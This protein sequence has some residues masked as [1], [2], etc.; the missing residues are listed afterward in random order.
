MKDF[1]QIQEHLRNLPKYS[2]KNEQKQ[3]ILVKL[4]QKQRTPSFRPIL[5]I[6][7]V[8]MILIVFLLTEYTVREDLF[9]PKQSQLPKIELNPQ[10]GKIFVLPD[11]KQ[12]VI[13]VEGKV[14]ILKVFNHIVA[15]DPRRISKLMI[16]YWGNSEKIA[17]NNYRIEAMNKNAEKITLAEGKLNSS[18]YSK[19][20]HTL[21]SFTPFPKEGEWQL[22]FYVDDSLFGEFTL[23]V[24]PPFPKTKH[25]ILSDSP[26]EIK[27]GVETEISIE[28]TWEDKKDIEVQLINNKGKIVEQKTFSQVG[29]YIDSATLKPLYAFQGKLM[30]PKKGIW[31]LV[32]DG[33]KTETFS[34]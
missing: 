18:L 28:S 14:A 7:A 11:T 20:A 31:T 8:F 24:L 32:I 5:S 17:W 13:G 25:Y 23:E 19:E 6:V 4:Q 30:F 10:A 3:K 1:K 33:E 21:T 27:P 12:E 26:K 22:S 9:V 29:Q 15:E 16:Y 2:L 34:N